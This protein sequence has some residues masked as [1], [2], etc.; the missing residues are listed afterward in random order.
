[1]S[2]DLRALRDDPFALLLALEQRLRSVRLDA[3][4]AGV[5]EVWQ[6]LAYRI[7]DRWLVSPKG[8]VREVIPPPRVT[9]VP[10][11]R[12]WLSGVANARGSLLTVVD[13]KQL[14]GG[15]HASSGDSRSARV[16]VL[17]SESVPAGFVVD[18]VAGYRQFTVVDQGEQA[19][20]CVRHARQPRPRVGHARDARRRDHLAHVALGRYQPAIAD[21]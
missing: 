15:G 20:P 5:T 1:M 6:G 17:N 10:N 3:A 11:A 12:P 18:E 16:L 7:G 19:A 9:R 14:T 8:D 2:A 13:L 21:A 4:V